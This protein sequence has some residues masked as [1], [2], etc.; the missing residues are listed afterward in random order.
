METITIRKAGY[1]I[2]YEFDYFAQ[3]YDVCVPGLKLKDTMPSRAKC[4]MILA[5]GGGHW[6]CVFDWHEH[7]ANA[8]TYDS[9]WRIC[10]L[11]QTTLF[12]FASPFKWPGTVTKWLLLLYKT[13]RDVNFMFLYFFSVA[14]FATHKT[15]IISNP[16]CVCA[17]DTACWSSCST[18]SIVGRLNVINYSQLYIYI[19]GPLGKPNTQS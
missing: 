17:P 15:R 19:A 18:C 9:F 4:E 14:A 5:S 2:R 10:C 7:T 16:L 6:H 1:P 12:Y 13:T 3:R 8:A 11:C